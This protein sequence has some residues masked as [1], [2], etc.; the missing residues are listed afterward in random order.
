MAAIST[1]IQ[2]LIAASRQIADSARKVSQIAGQAAAASRTGE[3]TVR[4]GNDASRTV[5]QQIDMT[6]TTC[7]SS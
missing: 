2:E 7:P 5:R 6:S 3:M 1:T 4:K